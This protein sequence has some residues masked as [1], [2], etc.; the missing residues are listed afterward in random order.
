MSYPPPYFCGM[1]R[2]IAVITWKDLETLSE[3]QI[4]EIT[5]KTNRFLVPETPKR[6]EKAQIQS[7][8]ALKGEVMHKSL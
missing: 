7:N 4:K 8:C 6:P 3:D 2:R 1:L 5:R